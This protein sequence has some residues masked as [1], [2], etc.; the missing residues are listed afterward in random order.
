M[1]QAALRSLPYRSDVIAEAPF[2]FS[3]AAISASLAGL[4][5]LVAG[6]RRGAGLSAGD[7]YRLREIVEFAFANVLFALFVI[8]LS[9]WRGSVEDAVRIGAALALGYLAAVLAFLRRR[10]QR[11][12][13]PRSTTWYVAAGV[14]NLSGAALSIATITTG[15]V[16][17]FEVLLLALLARPMVAFLLVLQSFELPPDTANDR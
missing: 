12:G 9:T 5:G 8:P 6:I 16:A 15:S 2:L 11:L 7:L 17:A 13:L 1:S 14:I 3:I 10:Q 4:A